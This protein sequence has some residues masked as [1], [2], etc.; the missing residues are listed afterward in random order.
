M[1]NLLVAD[2]G[3]FELTEI[4][5]FTN[6]WEKD[7]SARLRVGDETVLDVYEA[8][9]RLRGGTV[10][11]MCAA[12]V[13]GYLADTIAGKESLL[14]AARN[15]QARELSGDIR[16]EL[17]RLGRVDPQVI[18]TCRD[19]NLIGVGDRIQARRNDSSIQVD[20]AGK[21]T[22]R[23]TYEVLGRHPLTGALRVRDEN[24]LVAHLP[25]DYVANHVTLA[26]A[27]TAHAAEGRTVDTSH[28]L[29]DLGTTRRGAYVP[30]TRGRD[31]NTA[32]VVCERDPDEHHPD[33]IA[34]TA[35]SQMADVLANAD[36]MG[37]A[38]AELVRRAGVEE[39]R[40]LGWVGTQWDL[41]T[42]EYGAHRYTSS[43]EGLLEP[44]T[45]K[46]LVAEPGYGRLMRAV[47]AAELAGHDPE[48]VLAAAIGSRSLTGADSMSDVLRWRLDVQT[49]GRV[50]ERDTRTGDW[51]ALTA[52]I[53][54]PV[55]NYV[56][57][58]AAVAGDRQVEL[59]NRVAAELPEWALQRLGEVPDDQRERAEWV[60][61]AGVVAAYR[62]LRNVPDESVSL[63]GAP[64]REQVFHRAIWQQAHRAL[65]APA[66]ELDYLTATDD[67]LRE[68]RAV[69]Q[70]AQ[71]WA[72]YRVRAELTAARVAATGYHQ[73]AVLWSAEAQLLPEGSA[74][75]VR[76]EAD[77]QRA[78]ELAAQYASRAEQL[79]VIDTLRD[80]WNQDSAPAALRA[81]LAAK[82]LARRGLERDLNP[83][84][85]VQGALIDVVEPDD[86]ARTRT[87]AASRLMDP[88]QTVLDLGEELGLDVVQHTEE[89]VETEVRPSVTRERVTDE[90][91]L[92]DQR[93]Q[94]PER[95]VEEAIE[96]ALADKHTLDY[97][98][99]QS[100][101]EPDA[102]QEQLFIL[103]PAA[104][105]LAA[106]QPLRDETPEP[107]AN[108]ETEPM[109]T[110][111]EARREAE[112]RAALR[113]GRQAWEDA[114]VPAHEWAQAREQDAQER[115][116]AGLELGV[117]DEH[118]Q[119]IDRALG[120]DVETDRGIDLEID[121]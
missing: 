105:D 54:G 14:V 16:T 22:N 37:V 111:G 79:Q 44:A 26:Y 9:G 36:E 77:L 119:Q 100:G 72:P 55:G 15:D 18:G 116:N 117:A 43:L 66:D 32:Y 8:H 86:T 64:P 85:P 49:G 76:V 83:I 24:G 109:V 89:Q 97:G 93:K 39:S 25:K 120:R 73:D 6:A 71:N 62:E 107:A 68:M 57:A 108:R 52:P 67:E 34:G 59:G 48:R 99:S 23:A 7:A 3:C 74:Q 75:R 29:I 94:R 96:A 10:E 31:S 70:R 115:D 103:E 113:G 118:V 121:Y 4:H 51:A 21:I 63:G 35:R 1:L 104:G 88:A 92:S 46:T 87:G 27:S 61:R 38:A 40:S 56:A 47:R 12:A 2:N 45:A 33:R 110:V 41:L 50:P 30:L 91:E 69:W 11:E 102:N 28:D 13:R 80:Q 42:M 58:L 53:D 5:R 101:F 65:G 20:G 90:R 95:A 17:V 19:G 114:I 106:A 112:I 60:R 98:P 78:E 82:E 81:E 84:A